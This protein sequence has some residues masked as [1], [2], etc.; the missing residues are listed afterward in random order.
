MRGFIPERV[1]SEFTC[2][3]WLGPRAVLSA[4]F[5]PELSANEIQAF[6]FRKETA[7]VYRLCCP[8][9]SLFA[10]LLLMVLFV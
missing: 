9:A 2:F 1:G 8:V 6:I 10:K 5:A 3:R 7:R 4:S